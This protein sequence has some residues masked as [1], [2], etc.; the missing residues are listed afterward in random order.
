MA[1]KSKRSKS[2]SPKIHFGVNGNRAVWLYLDLKKGESKKEVSVNAA[3]L[4]NKKVL[5]RSKKTLDTADIVRCPRSP[6][7]ST[8]RCNTI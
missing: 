1:R 6:A 8:G 2:R 5:L 7:V 4:L 3:P